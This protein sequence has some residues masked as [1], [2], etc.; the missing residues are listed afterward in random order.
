MFHPAQAGA[1]TVCAGGMPS[2]TYRPVPVT[3]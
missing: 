2:R 1:L 3:P